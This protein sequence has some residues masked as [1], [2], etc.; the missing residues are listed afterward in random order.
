MTVDIHP[1]PVG[2]EPAA[3]G[4]RA[5]LSFAQ[6]Q[7]WFLDQLAP[8]ETTYNIL[9]A[10]RLRG[11]L[12]VGILRRCLD[13][14]VERHDVLRA[15]IAAQDGAPYQLIRPVEATGPALTVVDLTS[16]PEA[17]REQ[18]L[19]EALR[20]QIAAPFDLEHGPLYRFVLFQLAADE[21]VLCQGFHHVVTD[22]WSS[23]VMNAEISSA[24]RALLGGDEPVFA[25]VESDY[26]DYARRQRERLQGE[27]LEEELRFWEQRLER[28]P[29]LELPTDRP[30]PPAGNH[31]GDSV[32]RTFPAGLRQTAQALADEHGASLF[33]VLA[34][35]FNVVLGRYT[36]QEDIPVGVPMLGR[37]EPELEDVVGLFINMT[38]LRCDLSG[39]PSFADLLERTADANL[40][41]YEHQEVPFNLVVDRVAPTRDP[42]RNPLFQV[43]VQVLGGSTSGDNL[44][45]PGVTAE[46]V[47]L[48]SVKARFD[49]A[50]NFIDNG[51]LLKASVEYSADLFDRW[52]IEAL[53]GH[54]ET[55]LLAAAADPSLR[56]SQL[57]LLTD[58]ERAELLE[59][60]R[61]E[62]APY[63]EDL[64]H[65]TVAK[66]AAER[67]DAVAL[68]CKGNELTY[69]EFDR[70][71]DRL[72]RHLRTRGLKAGQVV[73]M[74]IDRD[75]DAY[76]ALLGILKAGGTFAVLDPK[77]PASRLDFMLRDTAAPLVVTRTAFVDRL[78][79]S[80][81]WKTVLLDADW[82]AIEAEPADAPLEEWAVRESL[83]YIL[84]TSGS[85][86]TPKGVMIAHQ[87]V[88]FFAEAYRRTFD[89]GPGDRL[90]QLPSLTFDMSQGE[91]WTAFLAGAT[92]VAVSPE[93][94]LSPEALTA[95]MR[96]QRVSYAGLPPAMLS[97]IEPEPYPA[98]KYVM[99]GAEVLPPELVNKWNLPGRR[100]VNLYGP[101]E[102]AIACTEYECEHVEW[103]SS[104]P[105]G[106]PEVNR[107]VYVVDRWNNL[108][109]RGVAG[110][111]LI[112]GEPGGLAQGYLNQPELTAEKFAADPFHP[113]RT[114]YRSGDLV[115]WDANLQLDFIG[116]VD[117][118]VKLRGLR[119][120][121]GEIESALV[122][123]SDVARAVV[124]MRPDRQ[125]DNRLIGYVTGADGA[126]PE[127]AA[128]AAHLAAQLPEYMVPTA[129]VVLEE[130]PLSSGWKIDRKALPDPVEDEGGDGGYVAPGTATETK[131][132]QIFAE[133]LAKPRVGAQDGFF[134]IGGNS[135]QAMRAVSRINKGFGI[136]ISIRLLYGSATVTAISAAI[137]ER[138]AGQDEGGSRG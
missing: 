86:G 23:A 21:Y 35:A 47:L 121:L 66:A 58:A 39:D 123:H 124:L 93:E 72:A 135:L 76:V 87:A 49:I 64:L 73:A 53:L 119:I 101:T 51:D 117:H 67:P 99:G 46:Y 61:G 44:F 115:R 20:G 63:S 14:I 129:W 70:R 82:P 84:Y 94:A 5:P 91:I 131:V 112:G 37:P 65:A 9:L 89:F 80:S 113:G 8:G 43:A 98:L 100:F 42:S 110:E 36:G 120:E 19:Q 60:G 130:F 26:P 7:L 54:V 34:A 13:L 45:L 77:H 30:R 32:I 118:Q 83:A 27:A 81:G 88:S 31:R 97:V 90:L 96:E 57:P 103:R 134:Q 125:G 3:Q 62:L 137:D 6:E 24:Y 71:A 22:G 56:I 25:D 69:A 78:P 74:V 48:P 109:P 12:N 28:L 18:A 104:P 15:V 127:P 102:A 114:V 55:V 105:I 108:V 41:L 132:A 138:L 122:A 133:V 40:D 33:M 92:V 126:A 107:Q 111:L 2:A 68:V 50:L 11:E 128:L 17:E 136:K 75:L 116:R 1:H 52:R 16:A 38:V 4:E 106:R 79:E 95:L 10:W 59:V 85:T 29:T